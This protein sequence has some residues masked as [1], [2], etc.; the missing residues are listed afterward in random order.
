MKISIIIPVYNVFDYLRECVQSVLKLKQNIEVILVDDGSKDN[1]GI[2]CDELAKEDSRV[3]VIHQEN[4]GL[5][6]ARNTGIENSSGDYVMF[7]DSDDFIDPEV[8]EK[9]LTKLSSKPDI[10]LG[11]YRN[12]YSD[13]QK[14]ENE[15]CDSFLKVGGE[16]PIDQFLTAVPKDGR[17][18]YMVAWRFIVRRDFL[19]HNNLLFK[20]GI[21]HEDEEWTQRLLCC[22][23]TITLTHDYFYQY[24]QAREGAITSS[25][26]P[27]HVWDIFT[28]MESCNQLLSNQKD[29]SAKQLYLKNR[30]AQLYVSNMIN[31]R[32]LDRKERG[33]AFKKLKAYT[34]ICSDSFSGSIG[35]CVKY[36]QRIF[37]IR[38]T[39]AL[40]H[41][42]R[43]VLK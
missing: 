3:L 7:L 21:Y 5:S 4:G 28:I 39:C 10:L 38:V 26:K 42:V 2:L 23:E 15:N 32:V 40:L 41:I 29:E 34:D 13:K 24:R 33:V 17:N 25:V 12:Y 35:K 36:C 11:L 1:S 22:A 30:M 27:K 9:M 31:T 19:M 6:K 8:T 14:Y 20:Q 18:C 43:A 16:M 37:G